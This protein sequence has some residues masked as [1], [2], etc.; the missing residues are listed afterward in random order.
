MYIG[1]YPR[2]VY[3]DNGLVFGFVFVS[4]KSSPIS[5]KEV[6]NDFE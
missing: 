4:C 6:Q 2:H 3:V 5:L 1:K